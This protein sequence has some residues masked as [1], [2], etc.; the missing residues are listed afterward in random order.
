MENAVIMAAAAEK[1]RQR[2]VEF[3][4]VIGWRE[5]RRGGARRTAGA[6][7]IQAASVMTRRWDL[8]L[9]QQ[10]SLKSPEKEQ[11]TGPEHPGAL[12]PVPTTPAEK[13]RSAQA[14]KMPTTERRHQK[15]GTWLFQLDS[16][17]TEPMTL[18][19]F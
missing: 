12:L 14:W 2:K 11:C 13:R 9:S 7:W 17:K 8:R 5:Q 3:Q 1:R 15:E 10:E 4:T 16:L 19:V 6:C 18:S